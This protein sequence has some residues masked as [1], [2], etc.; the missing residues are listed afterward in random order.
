MDLLGI[1][2]KPCFAATQHSAMLPPAQWAEK[3]KRV[4]G[5]RALLE[6]TSYKH[7]S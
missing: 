1:C 5:Y 6:F 4:P 3:G 2:W 7:S